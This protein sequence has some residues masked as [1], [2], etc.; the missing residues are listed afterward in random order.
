MKIWNS[1]IRV[2]ISI[3][4]CH[5]IITAAINHPRSQC[6]KVP[7]SA[8]RFWTLP[9]AKCHTPIFSQCSE[10]N[11]F[12]CHCHHR[13]HH[14]RIFLD[15]NVQ[16]QSLLVGSGRCRQCRKLQG[17]QIV[18]AEVQSSK[19]KSQKVL[20][21]VFRRHLSINHHSSSNNF[22]IIV[23]MV[24]EISQ[25]NTEFVHITNQSSQGYAG[26]H[27]RFTQ[28]YVKTTKRNKGIL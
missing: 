28:V 15:E 18:K 5:T 19:R 25:Y 17:P 6:S 11:N 26:L 2:N 24:H 1:G 23:H 7:F 27:R 22:F 9:V 16:F 3:S 10:H 20:T 21:V 13:F 4:L 8:E 12:E 14:E